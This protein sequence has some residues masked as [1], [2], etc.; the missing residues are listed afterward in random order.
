M[1]PC[2]EETVK[3]ASRI[4]SVS[5]STF[6]FVLQKITAWQHPIQPIVTSRTTAKQSARTAASSVYR[7]RVSSLPC[8][9]PRDHLRD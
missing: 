1:S 3:F 5:Q 2:M 6:L 8:A 4:L 7:Q 9:G